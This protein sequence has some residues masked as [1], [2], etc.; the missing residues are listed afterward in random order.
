MNNKADI[1]YQAKMTALNYL[2]DGSGMIMSEEQGMLMSKEQFFDTTPI[3]DIYLY[4]DGRISFGFC[5]FD[6]PDIK[7]V[8]VLYNINDEAEVTVT[9][10][11]DSTP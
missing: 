11:S 2:A 4:R 10:Y 1:D 7:S 5:R 3:T 9:Y 8:T 6:I